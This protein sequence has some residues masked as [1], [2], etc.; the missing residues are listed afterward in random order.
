MPPSGTSDDD[1][2][3]DARPTGAGG[4]DG[5]LAGIRVLDLSRV[6]SGP[7]CGRALADLGAEV[8]KVEP[9]EGDLS[10]F[11]F[12]KAG[13]LALYYVQQNAGKAN[14]SLD[15][16]RPEAADLL[17]RLAATAD[18]VLEN[19]RP[20]VMARHGLDHTTLAADHPGLITV[21]LSG[22]GQDGPWA[23]RR[24]YAVVT[25]A[26]MGMTAGVAAARGGTAANDPY[27]HADVYA[28]LCALAGLLA[29]LHQRHRTGRGQHVD[30][31]M[32]QA[33]LFA[34]E[35]VAEELSDAPKRDRILSFGTEASPVCRTGDGR[36]VT[37]AGHP[38]AAGTFERYCA[39]MG[40]LDLLADER[41]AEEPARLRHRRELDALVAAWVAT[42]PDAASVEQAMADV[43]LAVG[44]VRTVAEVAATD[45]AAAR[46]AI[47]EVDD[48]RGGTVR[49]PDSPWRF[50]ASEAGVRG[51]AAFRG[52]HNREVFAALGCS[53]ADLDRLEADGVLS[54]RL[55]RRDDGAR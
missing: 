38:C 14:V 43:G 11:G 3:R 49:L 52:E 29:A 16:T 27:S 46:R 5:P 51:P 20:G 39:A 54:S 55:P 35:K 45:W 50:S 48:R 41:F 2:D 17:R 28:G 44:A 30:V 32:G 40:R 21:S 23:G 10:R 42:R 47:V 22:Y 8:I 9:P 36:L 12:P 33:L 31:S 19:F 34:N 6:L 18:V 24:A 15:L 4:G 37:I 13:S 25:Q 53:D 7:I 1:T 26:E